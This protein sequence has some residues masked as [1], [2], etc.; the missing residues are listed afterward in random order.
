MWLLDTH[1]QRRCSETCL[2]EEPVQGSSKQYPLWSDFALGD[3]HVPVVV[4]LSVRDRTN[5]TKVS[6]AVSLSS[7]LL[8]KSFFFYIPTSLDRAGVDGKARKCIKGKAEERICSIL[9]Q[10]FFL[11]LFIFISLSYVF[12]FSLFC[13]LGSARVPPVVARRLSTA[14]ESFV[15]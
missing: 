3:L 8:G 15:F 1:L 11:F 10:I 13:V 12:F 6:P 5:T 4:R 7:P 9:L 14:F 2:S